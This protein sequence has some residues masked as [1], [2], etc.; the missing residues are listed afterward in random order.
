[1]SVYHLCRARLSTLYV[2]I[3]LE[4][5]RCLYTILVVQDCLLYYVYIT[6][7]I[8]RCLYTIF[9]EQDCLLYM[10][11]SHWRYRDVCIPSLQCKIVYSISLHHIGDIEMSVYHLCRARLSTLYVYITLEIQRCL[12]TIFVEQDCLLY[13]FTSHWRYRDVCI[14]SLQSK[15]VYSICLH[16]IGDIEM[17]VYH[18]CRA[19]LSTLYVYITLEIQRCLYTIFVVQDC[20]LYKFTSHWR[21]RDVCIP[22]LQCKIVYSIC[23]H[24]IGD[25]EMSV[26]HLCSARLSTLYVY[27]T[28]EIQIC[29]YTIFVEQDCLLYKFTS[30]W[31]YRDVC[32]PS[33]QSKIV[34]SICLH[35]IGDIEM[36]VYHLC[37]ARLST[38]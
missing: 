8:Q 17:S 34:Y 14:Q 9:V 29:L 38:L 37:S 7:E 5:Q 20:L 35:H 30:H 36:S 2:Y 23:L 19:R 11:T 22:S 13:K 1:M 3:T 31:R 26:Y 15:I 16:H 4:I 32:I 25:I 6:L 18:L 12:Y 33:L 27:I 21:Y 10:F 24:H 28:L